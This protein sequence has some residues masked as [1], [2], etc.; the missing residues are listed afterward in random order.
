MIILREVIP[1]GL[2]LSGLLIAWVVNA[3][4][5]DS[6]ARKYD[7]FCYIMGSLGLWAAGAIHQA[8]LKAGM[9]SNL[10]GNLLMYLIFLILQFMT[11]SYVRYKK[12]CDDL[13]HAKILIKDAMRIFCILLILFVISILAVQTWYY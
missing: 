5:E 11:T 8:N 4:I 2:M 6:R 1:V 10:I 9:R 12:K 3:K 7:C 13:Q